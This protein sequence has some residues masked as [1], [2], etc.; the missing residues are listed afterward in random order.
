M[1]FQRFLGVLMLAAIPLIRAQE[2]APHRTDRIIVKPN[3]Q[4][5]RLDTVHTNLGTRIA[6]SLPSLGNLSLVAI[7][8]GVSVR[9]ALA[10]FRDSGLVEYAEPDYLLAPLVQ[11]NDP[12]YSLQWP[13]GV[14]SAPAGSDI[15]AVRIECRDSGH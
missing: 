7:P 6:K 13:P 14:I 2:T 5:S 8:E 9:D 3:V 11:P 12:L 15:Q 10:R 4:L 1:M